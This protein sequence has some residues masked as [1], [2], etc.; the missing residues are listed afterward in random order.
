[1]LNWH[2]IVHCD[3]TVVFTIQQ[4]WGY[5]DICFD[6]SQVFISISLVFCFEEISTDELRHLAIGCIRKLSYT[7]LLSFVEENL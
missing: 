6:V 7:F 2:E 5:K 3:R 1:M 4:T